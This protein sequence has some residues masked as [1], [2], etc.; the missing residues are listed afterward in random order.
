[1]NEPPSTSLLLRLVELLVE[2]YRFS[3][4]NEASAPLALLSQRDQDKSVYIVSVSYATLQMASYK[5]R[6]HWPVRNTANHLLASL[7]TFQLR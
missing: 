1:M 5:L 7:D 2:F 4:T 6:L 3:D